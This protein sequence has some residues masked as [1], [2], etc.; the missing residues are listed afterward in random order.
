MQ[1]DTSPPV[2]CRDEV[3]EQANLH[4]AVE[5][6]LTPHDFDWVSLVTLPRTNSGGSVSIHLAAG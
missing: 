3:A 2:W 4:G 6:A 1:R 5:P